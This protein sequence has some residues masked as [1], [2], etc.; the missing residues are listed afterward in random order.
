MNR[1]GRSNG[2][3]APAG[4]RQR[5]PGHDLGRVAV[6]LAVMLADGG[7]A[8]SDLAVLRDREQL[9]GRWQVL[10]GDVAPNTE[11]PVAG[12]GQLVGGRTERGF[13]DVCDD[14]RGSGLGERTCRREPHTGAAARHQGYLSSEVVGR[15]H[16]P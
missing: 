5:Q 4:L 1:S 7:E 2:G 16:K 14:D 8:I 9:F 12:G 11:D 3:Q 13:V 15:I 10:V 6:D